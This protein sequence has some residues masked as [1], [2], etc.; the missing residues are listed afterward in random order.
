MD[1]KMGKKKREEEKRM[2]REEKKMKARV[3][4]GYRKCLLFS[5]KKKNFFFFNKKQDKL[6][7]TKQIKWLLRRINEKNE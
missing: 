4:H 5:L 7:R 3:S 6:R 2:D 1:F